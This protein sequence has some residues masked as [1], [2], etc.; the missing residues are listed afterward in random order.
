MTHILPE[1]HTGNKWFRYLSVTHARPRERRGLR[2]RGFRYV[3]HAGAALTMAP[4]PTQPAD[5]TTSLTAGPAGLPATP[6]A[7]PRA[8][9][10][11]SRGL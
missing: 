3:W 1:D 10:G 8:S 9:M 7:H 6:L 4:K 11:A 5:A 2:R